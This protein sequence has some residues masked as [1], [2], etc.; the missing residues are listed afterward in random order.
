MGLKSVRKGKQI[1]ANFV[2]KIDGDDVSLSAT[3]PDTKVNGVEM[4]PVY[5][6]LANDLVE[7]S[8]AK[9]LASGKSISCKAGCGACCVQAVP[10]MAFEAF[11]LANVVKRMSAAK[12]AVVR[13]RFADSKAR[14]EEAGLLADA[15]NIDAMSEEQR[16]V[17]GTRY[18]Q[19]GMAC[20]FLEK[21]SCSIYLDRPIRCREF[22]VT[23]DAKYCAQLNPEKI[24]HIET[25]LSLIPAL[26]RLS[27]DN[28]AKQNAGWMLM[29]FSLDWAKNQ[30]H[31]LRKKHGGAWLQEFIQLAIK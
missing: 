20:P 15:E 16:R 4:I 10:V 6:R 23:S 5:Q 9:T 11:H 13:Q 14:L 30:I 25:K 19:L 7:H 8:V 2:L 12:Q 26:N 1:T 28:I 21:G 17:F 22:L 27:R 31:K 24:D 29:N 3:V 18:F